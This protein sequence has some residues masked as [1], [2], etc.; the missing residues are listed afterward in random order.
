MTSCAYRRSNRSFQKYKYVATFCASL[1][2][3]S[4]GSRAVNGATA[5]FTV[6]QDTD[7][8]SEN[9]GTVDLTSDIGYLGDD[10]VGIRLQNVTI[11][12]GATITSATL[13]VYANLAGTAEF[14]TTIHAEDADSAST[15]TSS[16]NN[17]SNRTRTTAQTSWSEPSQSWSSGQSIISPNFSSVVQAVID[18]PGWS[19]GNSMAI[20]LVPD[21]G[22]K[23][24]YQH[25]GAGT[26]AP[27]LHVTYEYNGLVGHWKFDETSGTTASDSSINGNDGTLT[28]GPS[29]A[30]GAI[31]GGLLLDG[32]NDYINVPYSSE[33]SLTGQMSFAAW[34]KTDD[35]SGGYKNVLSTD[36]PGN[37]QS[38]YWFGIQNDELSFGF[39]ASG[40]FRTVTSP[41]SN[42]EAGKWY[43]VAASFDDSTDTVRLYVNG[44]EVHS[45]SLTYSPTP[46]TADLW[47]GHSVDGEYWNG[48]LDEVRIY[49]YELPAIEVAEL[50][51]LVGHWKFDEAAGTAAADSTAFG[52]DATLNGAAWTSDC[53]GKFGVEFDGLSDTATTDSSFDPPE[54]GAIALWLRSAGNPGARSR[55]FGV[56]GNWEM[57]QEP[58]G[59]L[60]FDLGGEGPDEGAG[61]DEFVTTEGL[62]FQDRWYHVIAQFDASDDSFEVYINGVLTDSGVNG[63]D[64]VKQVADTLTFGTRTGNT[65][66]WEGAIRDFR[67]YNRWLLN[68]EITELSGVIAHWK[69]DETSGTVAVDASAAGN[70]AT[71]VGSPTLGL[72]GAFPSA[73]ASGVELDGATQSITSGASLLNDL[74]QFTIAGWVRPDSTTPDRSLIG[75]NDLI[76]LGIDYVAN[77][78]DLWT[79]AGGWISATRYLPPGKW[80]HVL[81]TGDGT[82]LKIFVNGV[83]IASG[84]TSTANYGSNSEITKIGEGVMDPTGDYYDGRID[85]VI[86]YSRA[87][88]A[89]E[90]QGLYKGGRPAGVRI[91]KWV[92]IR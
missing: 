40:G 17:V 41:N 15:F 53:H 35:T 75:Q 90:A 42:L 92:E 31:D 82:N 9:S 19:S 29:W 87:V 69:L 33:L 2:L 25:T 52:N 23:S 63:D 24:I 7:D 83:E 5:T 70:D 34:I 4:I 43:H 21:S 79:N 58:D 14:D 68:A 72:P 48:C 66:F 38:N 57:R 12:A 11:P 26:N 50:Y 64:M 44:V 28:N 27:K 88:C 51:G 3:F 86:I 22:L 54:T 10:Y 20:I 59:T 84:G 55:P 76:E 46:E 91:L 67:V 61:G 80:S 8:A 85:D 74:T 71:Y 13:E 77:Q 36:V 32:S 30:E 65:E 56:G 81:A 60:S 1:T 18:R 73:T 37:G 45:G 16:A 6:S 62:S 78:I 89:E 47:I 49:N 39:W